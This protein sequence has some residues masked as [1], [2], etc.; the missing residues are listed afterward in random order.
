V[1]HVLRSGDL[2]SGFWGSVQAIEGIRAQHRVQRRRPEGYETEVT[3]QGQVERPEFLLTI[4]GRIDGL[5]RTASHV[6]LEEIKTTRLSFESLEAQPNPIHWGQLQCYGYL[7]AQEEALPFVELRLTYVQPDP[8]RTK[9]FIRR[10]DSDELAHFFNGVVT[11]Y[12]DWMDLV[13]QWVTTRDESAARLV[14]PFDAYRPGQRTLAVET[15]RTIRDGSHLIAQAPTGIGKTMAVLFPAVK[16]MAEQLVPKIIFLTARTTG[17]LVVEASLDIL[18]QK[19]LRL[20]TVSLTAKDKI[21]FMPERTCLPEECPYAKGY[22]DRL[23]SALID[24]FEHEAFTRQRIEEIARQHQVCPFEFSLE[25]VNWADGVIGDYNYAFDPHVVLQR[26]FIADGG[27]HAV[28]V[29]E[30]HNLVDRSR[31]MFSAQL[32]KGPVLSMARILKDELPGL[33]RRLNAINAWMASARRRCGEEG[34][35]GVCIDLEVPQKLLDR[36][37]RFITAAEKW[38]HNNIKAPF[39]EDLITLFFDC[40]RFMRIAEQYNH[41]Y[42]TIMTVEGKSFSIKLFC[43]DPALQLCEAW[44]R[45][46]SAVLFSATLSPADYYQ[47]ILGCS[48]TAKH[49][50]LPSPFPQENLMVAVSAISTLYRQRR[51]SCRSISRTMASLVKLHPGHYL[52]F[53]PSYEYLELI[54]QQFIQESHDVQVIVQSKEM[55]EEQ[56]ETFINRLKTPP[57]ATLVGFAVMGGIFGEGIDLKGDHLSAAVIVGVGLPG[58]CVEQE[59]IRA[60]FEKVKGMG[61]AFAYQ[62]PGI[63]R[64]LQAAGRVIRSESDRGIVL[65]IDQR[66]TTQSYRRLLPAHWQVQQIADE[67]MLRQ[68]LIE[69]WRFGN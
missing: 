11:Q 16:A 41:C 56:R 4:T 45:C 7:L 18:R 8:W 15:Y 23:N 63:T 25:L 9:T 58:I 14:F 36:L 57:S 27:R 38:L 5:L 53:F 32:A 51:A 66:Y 44:Q 39:R 55:N 6:C 35:D 28:L 19:G 33:R 42:T 3:V 50:K 48:E 37:R 59:I 61:F 43:V 54:H 49:L 52:F 17:R 46:R 13:V 29:D 65:L 10:M 64:V 60:Y 68:K 22:Y 40:V 20:K 21:C 1:E 24:A 69:F 2:Q 12:M 30:A 34:R 62:Y 26:L 47:S 67:T 31:E